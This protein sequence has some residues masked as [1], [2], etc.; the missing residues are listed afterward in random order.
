MA[1]L[2]FRRSQST[3]DVDRLRQYLDEAFPEGDDKV[4]L[5][6]LILCVRRRCRGGGYTREAIAQRA[7]APEPRVYQVIAGE[8]DLVQ[9]GSVE[10]VLR[11]LDAN[12]TELT[13]AWELYDKVVRRPAWS[14]LATFGP[15]RGDLA[16]QPVLLVQPFEVPIPVAPAPW[17]A[18]PSLQPVPVKPE[19]QA[20]HLEGPAATPS[21]PVLGPPPAEPAEPA[22][23]MTILGQDGPA[24]GGTQSLPGPKEAKTAGEFVTAMKVFRASKGDKPYRFMAAH[25]EHLNP[26]L[27]AEGKN[28]VTPYTPASF[29]TI[30][31]NGKLPKLPL[32]R[33]YVVGASG[34]LDDLELWEKAWSRLAARLEA[35][36]GSF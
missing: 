3:S 4:K 14:N 16:R 29:S 20:G 15:R 11:A 35:A 36:A 34:D 33:S 13:V 19:E 22:E 1:M 32:V 5:R 8:F 25:C 24:G 26:D 6:G 23:P 31:K 30:G 27:E 18:E 2:G 9:W 28:K 10:S 7:R 17:T 12:A 21:P